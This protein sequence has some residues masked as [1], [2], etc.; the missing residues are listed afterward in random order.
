MEKQLDL[1]GLTCP[2]PVLKTKAL[3]DDKEVQRVDVLVDGEVNVNNLSRLARSLK[4]MVTSTSEEKTEGKCFK[5]T[6][7]RHKDD[8]ERTTADAADHSHR[9]VPTS[10]ASSTQETA[11]KSKDDS[12][13]TVIFLSKDKFGDGDP[14]FSNTLLSLFLQTL[15]SSGHRPRAILLANTGVR[16]LDKKSSSYKA[17]EDFKAQGVEVLACGL[18]VEFYGLKD[19]IPTEQITNMFAIAEFLFAADKVLTP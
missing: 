8:A 17:L 11:A 19:Q 13:G 4:L 16:L 6:I 10:N 7:T 18:C 3:L 1:R 14:E 12:V 9:T 5:V 15:L 2:A